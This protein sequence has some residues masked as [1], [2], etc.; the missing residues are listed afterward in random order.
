[1]RRNL[2][3]L[4]IGLTVFGTLHAQSTK[5][6]ILQDLNQTGGI[7]YSY[8]D[9][10]G[11]VTPA[12]EGYKPF[13]INHY[14]RHGSR[15]YTSGSIYDESLAILGKAHD[16]GQLT[17]LGES[18]YRKVLVA[19]EDAKGRYGEL[20]PR[21]ER[22][23]R[24]IAERMYLNYPEV[25][26]TAD[27][28]PCFVRSRASVSGRCI[29][30]M[31]ASNER[32]K[33]LNPAIR[34]DREVSDRNYRAY[35]CHRPESM[36]LRK[37]LKSEISA[38]RMKHYRPERLMKSLFRDPSLYVKSREAQNALMRNLYNVASMFQD[39]DY[40][41]MSLYD[42]FTPDELF[43]VWQVRNYQMYLE[44]ANS[45]RFGDRVTGDA[46]PLL[47]NFLEHAD[48]AL[49]TGKLAASLRYGH[50]VAII[51]FAA[52]CG[53]EGTDRVESDYDKIHLAWCNYKVS[54]M[55]ANFQWIFFRKPGCD[56][57]LVKFVYNEQE[58]KLSGLESD[59]YPFYRWDEAWS[60]FEKRLGA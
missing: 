50:D 46:K 7:Y 10:P 53:V 13:F 25:F 59:L 42:I 14:G 9:R 5:E 56:E 4:L 52:L 11:R 26:S 38:V 29:V 15:W 60:Y 51:P 27:G 24:A 57:I 43:T 41:G 8:P 23:H 48:E 49:S 37:E 39:N 34:I 3:L 22:E 30:S 2:L 28:R 47:R 35:I 21:G 12:P 33:E 32:L 19:A 18:V 55:A 1:M 16:E 58:V 45:P 31:A 6:E 40:L 54:P 44:H 20:S 36:K 17:E